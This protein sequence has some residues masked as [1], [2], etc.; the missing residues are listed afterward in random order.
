M[1][2]IVDALGTTLVALKNYDKLLIALFNLFIHTLVWI[3]ITHPE[4]GDLESAIAITD[5]ILPT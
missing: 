2:H 4:M 5:F 3:K 1:T